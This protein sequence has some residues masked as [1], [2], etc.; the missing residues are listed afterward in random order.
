MSLHY[1][2]HSIFM[3]IPA[4]L[5]LVTVFAGCSDD[6]IFN[7]EEIPDTEVEIKGEVIFKPFVTTEVRTRSRAG[8]PAGTDYTGIKSL[9]VFFFDE[10]GN[11]STD[12][13]GRKYSGYVDFTPA[14]SEGSTHEHVT[15]KKSIK[16]GKYYVYAV[17][18]ISDKQRSAIDA[19]DNIDDLKDFPL[20]WDGEIANDLEMFGVFR[21]DGADMIPDND[22]FEAD[23]LLTI[24]PARS[25]IHSRVR[26]AMSKV[27]VN[28]DGTNLKENVTVYI[29]NA[30]LKHA[31]SHASL[32]RDGSAI[33]L[34]GVGMAGSYDYFIDYGTGTDY[35]AWQEVT[36][37]TMPDD[38]L[39][40]DSAQA[41]PCYENMQG[42][43][44]DKSKLQDAD[45]D[46]ILDDPVDLLYDD[47]KDGTYL[48]VE[49][50]YVADRP[51][52]K[53]HGRIIYR[54]MLGQDAVTNYD[55]IRNH[56][57]KITMCLK[58]YGNDVDW[59]IKYD[60][61]IFEA[62]Y[63]K[64]V[65]YRGRFFEPD[66]DWLNIYNA[67]HSFSDQNTITVTSCETDGKDKTWKEPEI[68]YTW[69]SHNDRTGTWE[70]DGAT[71]GTGWLTLTESD[72]IDN[73]QKQYTFVANEGEMTETTVKSLLQKADAKG[74]S[75][76]YYNLSGDN[77]GMTVKNTA[78]CYIVGAS[79]YYC[80]P[81]VYGN[82]ITDGVHNTA[83]Y[84]SPHFVTHR[85]TRITEPYIIDNVSLADVEVKLIW[86]DAEKLIDPKEIIYDPTLFG[87]KG[88]IKFHIS[89]SDICEGNAVIALIDKSKLT[90]DSWI[91][92]TNT[93]AVWSWHIWVTR[94]GF[95]DFEDEIRMLNHEAKAYD[96][97][98]VPL[99]WC[100][101][102][103]DIKYYKRRKCDIRFKVGDREIVRTI[104]QYPHLAVPRGDHPFY[105]WGRKDPFVG[106]NTSWGNKDRW[107]HNGTHY[108]TL[109][110]YN[111]PALYYI[112]NEQN[113]SLEK[114]RNTV[115][116]LHELIKN[117]DKFHDATRDYN[118]TDIYK[119][120]KNITY[121]NLWSDNG[122][123]T[124][125]DPC[126]PG[127][128]VGDADMFTGFTTTGTSQST[129]VYWNDVLEKD[130]V[131]DYPL[132]EVN[133][134]VIEFYTDSRKIQSIAF[135]VTGYRDFDDVAVVY[136]LFDH[137][138]GYSWTNGHVPNSA[139]AYYIQFKR[140]NYDFN[141]VKD[142]W[143][144]RTGGVY[145]K[146]P[147]ND[148]DGCAVRPVR[149]PTSQPNR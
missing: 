22:S 61:E 3:I 12:D 95:G 76:S 27:T 15:F 60:E 105:Q 113:A 149:I 68:S 72:V 87:D 70:I 8:A 83:A 6:F 57:Y 42:T 134:N 47:V 92:G 77:G 73:S 5:I 19:I 53:S 89:G 29:R 13:N 123:K 67:G 62:T 58:G 43:H 55:V 144:S 114:R 91:Q 84:S 103:S 9:Y 23:E 64:D 38:R 7:N 108:G 94:F 79:G 132:S 28:F 142:G 50:Y 33:G 16:A 82:A 102:G 145:T 90:N 20:A 56:H 141:V 107:D 146:D 143:K 24:I 106:S 96:A 63:P 10:D 46:G 101:D 115:D 66:N 130:M 121:D 98:S 30:T 99:G 133:K 71:A 110:D 75:G 119:R 80:F 81:L 128:R 18:N 129:G 74:S 93:Q 111:P 100:S 35:R 116:C 85:N 127:Y 21:Q 49:G 41:L 118:E 138:A 25:S 48:E 26:R 39:H 135:P 31:A 1:T 78:N 97:F 122:H 14:P 32:G 52:Y 54:F 86:Q 45:N 36:K 40:D 124:V 17:A 117:P 131:T 120:S 147:F 126:P 37:T 65:D 109:G 136:H 69:Y 44:G 4:I 125:Y 2:K 139:H 112:N 137:P 59:H 140:D 11:E 148:T 104:E 34:N 88:G 51:E